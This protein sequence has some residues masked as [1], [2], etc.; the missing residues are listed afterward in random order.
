[1]KVGSLINWFRFLKCGLASKDL[2]ELIPP[3]LEGQLDLIS[4]YTSLHIFMSFGH[5]QI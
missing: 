3:H 1:M 4:P 2:I 5:P